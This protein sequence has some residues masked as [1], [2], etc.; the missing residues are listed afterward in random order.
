MLY[1]NKALTAWLTDKPLVQVFLPPYS[2]NMN[3]IER[4]WKYLRQKIINTTFHRTKS[5]LWISG[6]KNAFCQQ[7]R[8]EGQGV[9]LLHG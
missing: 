6:S 3:L 1:K 5:L 8:S 4:L 9:R 7:E 2:P